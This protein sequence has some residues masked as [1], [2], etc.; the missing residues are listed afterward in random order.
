M[1]T[2]LEIVQQFRRVKG[3]SAPN[4]VL[5]SGD[6]GLVQLAALLKEGGDEISERGAWEGLVREVTFVTIAVEDQGDIFDHAPGMRYAIPH[7]FW[8]RTNR[9]PLIGPTDPDA[10]QFLKAHGV[11]GPRYRFRQRGNKLLINPA[12]PAGYTWAFEYV[13]SRWI[14][15][16]DT[17]VYRS[18]FV[19]DADIILLPAHIMSA[20]LRWRYSKEKGLAY[21]EEYAQAERMITNALARD[22][23]RKVIS[24]V[25]DSDGEIRPGFYYPEGSFVQPS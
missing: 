7:T 2:L 9:L 19:H 23:G 11:Q 3:L 13:D 25:G 4:A 20:T 16:S 15:D 21:D 18:D 1:A 6:L 22:G 14:Q 12:P 24:M 8:D 17:A 5:G 10:W